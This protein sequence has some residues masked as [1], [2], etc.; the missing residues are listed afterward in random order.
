M[1]IAKAWLYFVAL[2]SHPGEDWTQVA[3][4]R[5]QG[6]FLWVMEVAL[7]EG[8]CKVQECSTYRHVLFVEAVMAAVG[9]DHRVGMAE[10]GF[11]CIAE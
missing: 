2:A 11:G 3:Q 8:N 6:L 4:P 10:V 7:V 5:V 9:M 1:T